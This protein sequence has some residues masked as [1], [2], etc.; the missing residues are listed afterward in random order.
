MRGASGPLCDLAKKDG[1]HP[2]IVPERQRLPTLRIKKS[3]AS[4][5]PSR[6][7]PIAHNAKDRYGAFLGRIRCRRRQGISPGRKAFLSLAG[8]EAE[9]TCT[10]RLAARLCVS[11]A[12]LPASAVPCSCASDGESPLLSG[13]R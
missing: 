3:I 5:L 12:T 13:T 1:S 2:A 4:D 8:G 6:K 7:Q 10:P 9:P 11:A